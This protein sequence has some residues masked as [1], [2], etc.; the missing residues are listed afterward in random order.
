MPRKLKNTEQQQL[1][2]SVLEFME[3]QLERT[4]QQQMVDALLEDLDGRMGRP[5]G[6]KIIYTVEVMKLRDSAMD[7]LRNEI[8]A[9]TSPIC[10]GSVKTSFKRLNPP[11]NY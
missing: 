9:H 11:R 1:A 4:E 10:D 6:P 2:T 7:I 3:W 8:I 5:R